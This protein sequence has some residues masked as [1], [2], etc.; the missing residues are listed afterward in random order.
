MEK[1]K[2]SKNMLRRKIENYIKNYYETS[3][4]ALLITGARQVGKTFSIRE[5]GKTFKSFVEINFIDNP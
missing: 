3:R 5:F 2:N 1:W 4:N